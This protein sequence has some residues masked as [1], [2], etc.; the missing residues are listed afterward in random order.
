MMSEPSHSRITIHVAE[1]H[2]DWLIRGLVAV[3]LTFPVPQIRIDDAGSLKKVIEPVI[4]QAEA[5]GYPWNPPHIYVMS[6][7]YGATAYTS[8]HRSY[9]GARRKLTDCCADWG[10]LDLLA[11]S[12]MGKVGAP[13]TRAAT[14]DE[15]NQL[16]YGIG[17]LEIEE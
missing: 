15:D 14:G 13:D 3:Q 10:I 11:N 17:Y 1:D 8:V 2:D 6:L 16:T 7:H 5:A 4:E 12:E 9:Q